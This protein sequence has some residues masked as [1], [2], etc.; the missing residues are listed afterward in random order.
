[1]P[2]SET[3]RKLL[4]KILDQVQETGRRGSLSALIQGARRGRTT[5][6]LSGCS[7]P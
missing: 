2:L 1:M 3:K 5:Q 6:R 4:A 7:W